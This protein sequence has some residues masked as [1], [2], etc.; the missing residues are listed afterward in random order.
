[1]KV[2]WMGVFLVPVLIF[3]I[4]SFSEIERTVPRPPI[5]FSLGFTEETSEHFLPITPLASRLQHDN[6]CTLD[7]TSYFIDK[8]IGFLFASNPWPCDRNKRYKVEYCQLCEEDGFFRISVNQ[9]GPAPEQL[10]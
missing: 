7:N 10:Q 1:M 6:C 5:H 3:G 4:I 9:Q 2:Q 8:P